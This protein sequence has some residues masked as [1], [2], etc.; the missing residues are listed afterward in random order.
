MF[1][2][3]VKLLLFSLVV[4]AQLGF[5]GA[6]LF[7]NTHDIVIISFIFMACLMLILSY[8]NTPLKPTSHTFENILTVVFVFMGAIITY[9]LHAYGGLNHVLAAGIV[10]LSVS[11][12]PDMFKK[13]AVVESIPAAVY[14][15]AFVGMTHVSIAPDYLFI[16]IASF[17][18]GLLLAGTKDAFHGVGGKLGTLAFSGVTL[19]FFIT[20]LISQW[21]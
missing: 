10:G 3:K 16:S 6:I 8:K 21:L 17:F 13:N 2:K 18:T 20:F 12:L 5:L 1:K 4:L 14:C 19:A 15:G 7:E 9:T 11:F